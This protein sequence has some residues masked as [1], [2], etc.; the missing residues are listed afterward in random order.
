MSKWRRDPAE[1]THNRRTHKKCIKCR[2]WKPRI[3]ILARDVRSTSELMN[4]SS[5]DDVVEKHGFGKHKDSSDGLQ[6]ICYAC[7]NIMNNKAREKNVTARIRHHTAT[8]CLTQ[9]GKSNTPPNFV[10]NLEDHL[11]YRIS[12]L[13]KHLSRD[14]KEREGKRR[15]L[16]DALNEGYHIDHIRPLS[17]YPVVYTFVDRGGETKEKVDWGVFR[18]CWRVDN[19]TA[20]PALENLQKGARYDEEKSCN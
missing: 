6:S 14:L 12:T 20:I 3:D 2:V 9:L 4:G 11:G 5:P 8:R 18:E 7:K 19:L 10:T 17:S 15:K 1:A 13:V 16:R